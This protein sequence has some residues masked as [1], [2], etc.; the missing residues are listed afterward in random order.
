MVP[1]SVRKGRAYTVH[2]DID[3]GPLPPWLYEL[4]SAGQAR[5]SG[6]PFR[7]EVTADAA[8][9]AGALAAIPNHDVI[10]MT[11]RRWACGLYAS[12][13]PAGFNLFDQ[14]SQKSGKYD[15]ENTA[16]AWEEIEASPPDRTGRRRD[17]QAGAPA[18]LE[19]PSWS[20]C[21][22]TYPAADGD[23]SAARREIKGL[24]DAFWAKAEAY[25]ARLAELPKEERNSLVPPVEAIRI[26]TGLGKTE[27]AIAD[28]AAGG[29]QGLVYTVD[30]HLLGDKI[31]ERLAAGRGVGQGVPWPRRG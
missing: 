26:E 18:W 21:A 7:G 10:G 29:R 16:E 27:Q 4:I 2:N 15:A 6:E 1:P 30:R 25:H 22:P 5:S 14:W 23:I 31:E 12:L 28:V 19:R 8:E 11:G 9:L 20:E 3:P 24:I 17:L 13:G